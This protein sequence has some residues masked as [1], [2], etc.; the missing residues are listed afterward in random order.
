MN[1]NE[2]IF[3]IPTEHMANVFGGCDKNI[4][5]IERALHVTIAVREGGMKILGEAANVKSASR[6]FMELVN[7]SKRGNEI[8]RN[9]PNT[10]VQCRFC[11]AILRIR[12]RR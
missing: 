6:V 1:L 5:K 2:E 7:L 12:L 9:G 8:Y 4:K 11:G 10:T 3:D